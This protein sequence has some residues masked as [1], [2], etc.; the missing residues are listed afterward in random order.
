MARN[1]GYSMP[2]YISLSI[3]LLGMVVIWAI[4]LIPEM[5]MYFLYH[6]VQPESD[7]TRVLTLMAFW[8]GGGGLCV[9]LGFLGIAASFAWTAIVVEG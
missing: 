6:L 4:A 9:L 1:Y 2:W 3:W 5:V 7:L 8:L